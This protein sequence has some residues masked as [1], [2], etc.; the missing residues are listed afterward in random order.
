MKKSFE[1]VGKVEKCPIYRKNGKFFPTANIPIN[2][3]LEENFKFSKLENFP[4]SAN[5]PIH[6]VLLEKCSPSPLGLKIGT[7][8]GPGEQK[9][10]RKRISKF[11]SATIFSSPKNS[12]FRL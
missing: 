2:Q 12:D 8:T 9:Y 1:K 3:I 11:S 10:F 5:F 4:P 7:P 6:L